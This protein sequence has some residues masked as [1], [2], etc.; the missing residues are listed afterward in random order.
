MLFRGLHPA[1]DAPVA[2]DKVLPGLKF[3]AFKIGEL[4][5]ELG[6]ANFAGAK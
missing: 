3:V 5:P 6:T 4:L 2:V 1:L